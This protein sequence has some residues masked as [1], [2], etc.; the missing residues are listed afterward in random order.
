MLVEQIHVS[1]PPTQP[2]SNS[3][4]SNHPF[5]THHSGELERKNSGLRQKPEDEYWGEEAGRR[6]AFQQEQLFEL[7]EEN[8]RLQSAVSGP[9][10]E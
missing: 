2:N 8:A 7:R 10:G 9:A 3:T 5:H 4:T 6:F 1:K